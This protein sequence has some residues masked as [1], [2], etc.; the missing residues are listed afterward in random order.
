[1]KLTVTNQKELDDWFFQCLMDGHDVQSLQNIPKAGMVY[2]DEQP[3]DH[4]VNVA[5]QNLTT[6]EVMPI[7]YEGWS[8][9]GHIAVTR[10][11][12]ADEVVAITLQDED[13]QIQSVIWEKDPES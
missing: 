7:R 11:D 8:D 10:V 1:M 3:I 6:G 2:S 5:W 12:G 9:Q 4:Y 13:G